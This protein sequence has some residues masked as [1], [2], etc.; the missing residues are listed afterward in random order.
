MEIPHPKDIAGHLQ[1]TGPQAHE[2]QKQ[3]DYP[4]DNLFSNPSFLHSLFLSH[5][6]VE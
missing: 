5:T 1:P 4:K 6:V 3:S 2:R